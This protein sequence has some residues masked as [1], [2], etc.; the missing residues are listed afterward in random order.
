MN[1]KSTPAPATPEKTLTPAEKILESLQ[2]EKMCRAIRAIMPKIM[3]YDRFM[4]M[5]VAAT[6]VQANSKYVINKA[7]ILLCVYNAAKWGLELNDSLGHAYLVPFK[8]TCTLIVGYKG[9]LELVRRS[10]KVSDVHAFI[11]YEKDEFDYYVDEMGPHMTYRPTMNKDRGKP[12]CGVSVA[13]FTAGNQVPSIDVMPYDRIMSIRSAALARTPKSPWGNPL[14]EPEMAK[15]TV[16]RHHCKTLPMSAEA[17]EVIDLDEKV[18]RDEMP[19]LDMPEELK[20]NISDGVFTEATP[21]DEQQAGD[22]QL[23][24]GPAPEGS[25]PAQTAKQ[26]FNLMKARALKK[27]GVDATREVVDEIMG[28]HDEELKGASDNHE[29]WKNMAHELEAL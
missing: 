4:Q 20:E 24:E 2:S 9:L 8:Q 7:S 12:I 23:P 27:L 1:T 17:A 18:E 6:K 28:K 11:V 16:L 10:E 5:A 29:V 13:R 15:K 26:R 14:Y 25:L 3:N 19:S 21:P 22:G